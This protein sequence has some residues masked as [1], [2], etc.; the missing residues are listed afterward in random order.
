MKK[1]ILFLTFLL[2][3]SLGLVGCGADSTSSN[4]NQDK[5]QTEISNEDSANEDSNDGNTGNDSNQED[6]SNNEETSGVEDNTAEDT[7]A[8]SD[9][10]DDEVPAPLGIPVEKGEITD[11]CIVLGDLIIDFAF[12]DK[13]DLNMIVDKRS[14]SNLVVTL[15][16]GDEHE[17]DVQYS[18]THYQVGETTD[19]GISMTEE[20]TSLIDHGREII[21]GF[22]EDEDLGGT[23]IV[24]L[25][26]VGAK[27]YLSIR[28]FYRGSSDPTLIVDQIMLKSHPIM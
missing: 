21:Y 17:M 23:R 13:P 8:D 28:T 24:I 3:L 22:E 15:N 7:S 20:Y 16:A 10:T 6:S 25:Q 18:S 11:T 9:L 19:F 26:D 2:T 14:D 4:D 1:R 27:Y 12:A 5:T